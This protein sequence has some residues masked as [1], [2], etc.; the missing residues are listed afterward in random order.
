MLKILSIISQYFK[1]QK[2]SEEKKELEEYV[3]ELGKGKRILGTDFDKQGNQKYALFSPYSDGSGGKVYLVDSGEECSRSN[4]VFQED[5]LDN[6][7]L[8]IC[9]IY[10]VNERNIGW[11]SIIMKGFL[12][13]ARE[14]GYK[15]VVGCFSPDE[16]LEDLAKHFYI[17]HGFQ[18]DNGELRKNLR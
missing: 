18:I 16:G 6:Q 13:Y 3:G 11:G 10:V 15:E 7:I 4:L 1:K 8:K 17:K 2:P 12:N 9:D 5:K 14:E